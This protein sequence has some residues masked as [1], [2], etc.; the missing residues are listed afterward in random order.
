LTKIRGEMWTYITLTT[1]TN[2]MI[3]SFFQRIN[4][5]FTQTSTSLHMQWIIVTYD[6]K[7]AKCLRRKLSK[8]AENN[9]H[10]IGPSISRFTG[11]RIFVF[12]SGVDFKKLHFAQNVFGQFIIIKVTTLYPRWFRSNDT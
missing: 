11:R 12:R 8:I 7:V 6:K 4:Q 9:Y 5:F 2:V 3:L 10:N 1:A